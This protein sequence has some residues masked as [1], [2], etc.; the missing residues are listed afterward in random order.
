MDIN[1][2]RRIFG[3]E[4]KKARK[5][6]GITQEELAKKC[7]LTRDNIANWESAKSLPSLVNLCKLCK[8]MP[9]LLF[10]FLSNCNTIY[11]GNQ[12]DFYYI[13]VYPKLIL[14]CPRERKELFEQDC[15]K[16]DAFRF[17]GIKQ[18]KLVIFCSKQKAQEEKEH[19]N[20]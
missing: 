16:C 3:K 15:F 19:G 18:G 7:G 11:S 4:L 13:L 9:N 14:Y 20:M 8:I 10:D 5:H 6:L 2:L 17:I 1:K 12:S